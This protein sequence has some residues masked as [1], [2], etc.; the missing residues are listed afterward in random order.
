MQRDEEALLD[1]K[2]AAQYVEAF[3][4]G[5]SKREFK[6]DR[7]TQ[8]AVIHQLLVI[9]EATKRLSDDFRAAH[10]TI[11]WRPMA[12]MRDRLIH[13]YNNV[14]LEEVWITATRDI[15]DLLA[16]LEASGSPESDD[17]ASSSST[18]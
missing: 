8:F 16:K 7:R 11:P 15:P 13:D 10:E 6:E 9:G 4:E 18:D 5:F 1:I 3:T 14:D 17:P 2:N 12:G